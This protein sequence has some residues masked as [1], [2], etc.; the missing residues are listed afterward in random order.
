LLT[1]PSKSSQEYQAKLKEDQENIQNFVEKYVPDLLVV[2]ADNLKAKDLLAT[3]REQAQKHW[4]NEVNRV[5]IKYG[6]LTAP[7]IY[8]KMDIARREFKEFPE[9]LLQC[10]SLARLQ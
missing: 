1:H 8:A 3:L 9:N 10:I 2:G 5:W 6:D 4:N 7:R